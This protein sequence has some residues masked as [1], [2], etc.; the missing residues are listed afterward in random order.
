MKMADF[1]KLK[2]GREIGRGSYGVVYE[3]EWNGRTVAV[4]KMHPVLLQASWDSPQAR[5]NMLNHFTR[6]AC[7][8][9]Q[10]SHP[11]IVE[12]LEVDESEEVDPVIV[13]ERLDHSLREHLKRYAGKL[14][15]E[16]QISM[17]LQIAD[18]VHYLHSQQPPVVYRDLSPIHILVSQQDILK[19]GAGSTVVRL[20]PF[21]F[22]DEIQPGN[23]FYVAPETLS[24][25][26]RYN[27]KIDIF[28]FGVLMLEVATQRPPSCKLSAIYTVS[29]INRRAEDLALLLEGHPLKPIILQCLRDDPRARPDIGVVLKMLPVNE[30]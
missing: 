29:E 20:P 19:L 6:P 11:H 10:L 13:M 15:C 23:Q 16:R 4:K 22:L 28:S 14:S 18:A 9:R 26:A 25:N 8:L 12:I 17:C 27:E 3:S 5:A 1:G 7:L 30:G 21:G 24:A 2:K